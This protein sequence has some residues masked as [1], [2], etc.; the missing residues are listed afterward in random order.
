MN[1]KRIKN[2]IKIIMIV[3]ATLIGLILVLELILK[4]PSKYGVCYHGESFFCIDKVKHTFHVQTH[5]GSGNPGLSGFY[6]YNPITKTINSIIDKDDDLY[7][8]SL[9]D[10]KYNVIFQ[11]ENFFVYGYKDY[12]TE[13]LKRDDSQSIKSSKSIKGLYESE[14]NTLSLY[15]VENDKYVMYNSKTGVSSYLNIEELIENNY[16]I[17]V[18]NKIVYKLKNGATIKLAY[19]G[20]EIPLYYNIDNIEKYENNKKKISIYFKSEK[21]YDPYKELSIENGKLKEVYDIIIKEYPLEI[22]K[23]DKNYVYFTQ[24]SGY[25][26]RYNVLK[27]RY[28][29]DEYTEVEKEDLE[30]IR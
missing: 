17:D 5:P 25:N 13:V 9:S 16:F 6:F 30:I 29:I 8:Y 15:I 10:K 23:W 3:I 7:M 12:Y 26:L 11:D 18:S 28:E 2:I 19:K 24:M 22:L 1:R 14:D 27:N 21:A 20:K 4:M